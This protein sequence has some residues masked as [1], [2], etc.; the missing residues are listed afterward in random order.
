M[1]GKK[2]PPG[3]INYISKFIFRA[4]VSKTSFLPRGWGILEI[5]QI[6]S[7]NSVPLIGFR[8]VYLSGALA[9]RAKTKYGKAGCLIGRLT[10]I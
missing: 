3:Y 6:T 2:M 9:K 5:E 1:N 4:I 8:Y 10:A 7:V